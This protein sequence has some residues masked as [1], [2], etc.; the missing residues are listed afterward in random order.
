MKFDKFQK[1]MSQNDIISLADIAREL[2]VS[3]QSISN[4]KS[5]GWIPHKYVI[6]IEKN[7]INND[8]KKSVIRKINDDDFI[9]SGTNNLFSL[10]NIILPIAKNLSFILKTTLV[11]GVIGFVIFLSFYITNFFVKNDKPDKIYTTTAKIVIPGG[12]QL[13]QSSNSQ[14]PSGG[15]LS[16]LGINKSSGSG[17]GGLSPTS[18]LTSPSLYPQFLKTH[19][20]AKRLFQEKFDTKKYGNESLL[21]IVLLEIEK[22]FNKPQGIFNEIKQPNVYKIY[23][24][25]KT[26][27]YKIDRNQGLDT[28]I[29]QYMY[30]LNDT[31]GTG[32]VEF[33]QMGSFQTITT[34][35]IEPG[36]AVE[37]SYVVLQELQEFTDYFNKIDLNRTQNFIEQR[38]SVVQDEYRVLEEKMKIFL[39]TNRQISSPALIIQKER[40]DRDL[41]IYKGLYTT[42]YQNLEQVKIQ[43]EYEMSPTIQI[44]DHPIA[45]L[46]PNYISV[47]SFQTLPPLIIFGFIIIGFGFGV[48]VSLFRGYLGLVEESEKETFNQFREESMKSLN[49]FFRKK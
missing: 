48:I 22:N 4:W 8:I 26:G 13:T 27:L 29:M 3:P 21:E 10:S 14:S 40:I 12:V 30:V 5:R 34:R 49:S 9:D 2:N 32:L 19:S 39:E 44:L 15:I 28:L 46:Y 45:P 23:Q 24:E 7:F 38:L 33:A 1:I 35:A 11:S 42:L 25:E 41:A 6:I 36:L 31:S 18:T 16:M 17:G 47:Q 43:K 20:F 37:M